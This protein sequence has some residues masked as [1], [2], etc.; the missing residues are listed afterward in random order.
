MALVLLSLQ[1][2]TEARK[3]GASAA[4]VPPLCLT[5]GCTSRR[6]LCRETVPEASVPWSGDSLSPGC[7]HFVDGV[8]S[9]MEASFSLGKNAQTAA[10]SSR[11]LV[12]LVGPRSKYW[13]LF[14]GVYLSLITT[15]ESQSKPGT[16]NVTTSLSQ[17]IVPCQVPITQYA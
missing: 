6:L 5:Y 12:M 8:R 2:V 11:L 1:S 4:A 14:V 16:Q 3:I 13:R 17:V 10:S 15:S 7:R 9:I